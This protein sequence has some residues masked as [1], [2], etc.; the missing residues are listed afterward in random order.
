MKLAPLL[1]IGLGALIPI[2]IRSADAPTDGA[3]A[4]Q[5]VRAA[6]LVRNPQKPFRSV[7]TL[8]QYSNG[9]A[10][11]QVVVAVYVKLDPIIR[12]PSIS[13]PTPSLSG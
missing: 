5:L 10:R 4:E 6:D 3:Q 2:S 8:T 13:G 7:A 1:L 9:K 11:D 12:L